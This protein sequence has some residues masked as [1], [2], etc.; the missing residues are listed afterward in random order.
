MGY[1]NINQLADRILWNSDNHLESYLLSLLPR[2]V[3]I[4]REH[5]DTGNYS[6][7]VSASP[8]EF[9]ERHSARIPARKA[10]TPITPRTPSPDV[11]VSRSVSWSDKGQKKR[12]SKIFADSESIIQLQ[13]PPV[14]GNTRPTFNFAQSSMN[15][16]PLNNHITTEFAQAAAAFSAKHFSGSMSSTNI[17]GSKEKVLLGIPKTSPRMQPF[18]HQGNSTR[19]Q[20]FAGRN[21][22]PIPEMPSCKSKLYVSNDP[23]T[24]II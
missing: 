23:A 10:S 18:I 17:I 16:M 8:R 15:N 5:T 19:S 11:A 7:S 14:V 20:N 9:P 2:P 4:P 1:V 3:T 24:K 6:F 12:F 13:S 22:G 21:V